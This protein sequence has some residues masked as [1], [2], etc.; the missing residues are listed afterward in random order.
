MLTTAFHGRYLPLNSSHE[1]M[2][3]AQYPINA[4]LNARSEGDQHVSDVVQTMNS[5]TI[6]SIVHAAN[7]NCWS[8]FFPMLLLGTK[9]GDDRP[10]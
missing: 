2:Y 1:T 5:E 3:P 10:G 4:A 7:S 8:S 9:H 6:T